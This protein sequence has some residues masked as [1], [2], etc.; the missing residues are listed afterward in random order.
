MSKIQLLWSLA[1]KYPVRFLIGYFVVYF[2]VALPVLLVD[3]NKSEFFNWS[4]LQAIVAT[5]FLIVS[6]AIF[7]AFRSLLLL[8]G[9]DIDRFL[10]QTRK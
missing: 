4:V 5:P 1:G 2:I 3:A 7:F 9:F 8:V 6:L 10:N